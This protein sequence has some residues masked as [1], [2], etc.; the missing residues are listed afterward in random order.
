MKKQ[1]ILSLSALAFLS[2]SSAYA[3]PADSVVTTPA[4]VVEHQALPVEAPQVTVPAAQAPVTPATEPVEHIIGG[5]KTS[6]PPVVEKPAAAEA[7]KAPV[8]KVKKVKKKVKKA[9][10][11]HKKAE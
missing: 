11:S 4:P 1:I 5:D 8:K 2:L 9:K 6:L 3:D 10:K 7:E